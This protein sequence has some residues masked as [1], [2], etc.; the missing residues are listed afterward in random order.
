MPSSRLE[1]P[2]WLTRSAMPASA[3]AGA[4][5]ASSEARM[6]A[7][8]SGVMTQIGMRLRPYLFRGQHFA[9]KHAQVLGRPQNEAHLNSGERLGRSEI[10]LAQG[11]EVLQLRQNRRVGFGPPG[12]QPAAQS[13]CQ[14]I[15]SVRE[16]RVSDHCLDGL[17]AAPNS[18]IEVTFVEL[19]PGIMEMRDGPRE[20]FL[21]PGWDPNL[22]HIK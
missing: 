18:V 2:D 10:V 1:S 15:G 13:L 3:S 16:L 8:M 21:A 4:T 12:R 14:V 9:K 7:S 5:V 22:Q 17:P 6:R 19:S 11:G 20:S